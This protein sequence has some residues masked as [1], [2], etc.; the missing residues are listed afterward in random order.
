MPP[1]PAIPLP[2]LTRVGTPAF[3]EEATDVYGRALS[4]LEDDGVPFLIGGALA[5]HHHTGIWR[6]TK[7][8]DVFC[9]PEDAQQALGALAKR[10]FRPEVVYESWLGK[11]WERNVFVDVIWRNANALFPVVDAWIRHAAWGEVL[12]HDVRIL[13]AEE[14]IL[15]KITV[16][17]RHRFDGADVLHILHKTAE[18]IDWARLAAGAGEHVGLIAAYLHMYRW[19]YPG[20]AERIPDDVLAMFERAARDAP[21]SFGPFRARLLDL[22]T[23]VVDVRDWGLPDPHAKALADIFGTAVGHE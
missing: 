8:L 18:R 11:A 12:G 21:S 5:V 22:N 23:F 6:D 16:A 19:G 20:A 15:S 2:P 9:R 4:A 10:G 7:D 14:L 1:P 13:A 3:D 17:G